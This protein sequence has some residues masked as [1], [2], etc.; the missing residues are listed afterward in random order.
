MVSELHFFRL[1]YVLAVQAFLAASHKADDELESWFF[2]H[3]IWDDPKVVNDLVKN[4]L[5]IRSYEAS[6]RHLS[7]KLM[8][9]LYMQADSLNCL[10]HVKY[11]A[12]LMCTTVNRSVC[13]ASVSSLGFNSACKRSQVT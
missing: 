1:K 9:M 6:V 7:F 10:S 2:E 4:G 12:P 13:M 11:S 3:L 5:F 8:S